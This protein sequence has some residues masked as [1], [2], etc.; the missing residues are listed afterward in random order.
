M[1]NQGIGNINIHKE[2]NRNSYVPYRTEMKGHYGNALINR[3]N[4]MPDYI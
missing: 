4:M 2:D 3:E 1:K